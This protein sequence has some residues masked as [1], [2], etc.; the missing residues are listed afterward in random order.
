MAMG[1][2]PKRQGRGIGRA[3]LLRGLARVDESGL[4]AYLEP[5]QESTERLYARRGFGTVR[6]GRVGRRGPAFITMMRPPG[7]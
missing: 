2:A 6:R 1:V 4:P 3:L 5:F 7:H